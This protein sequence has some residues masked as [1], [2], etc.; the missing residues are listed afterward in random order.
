M[1]YPQSGAGHHL[2][3][4]SMARTRRNMKSSYFVMRSSSRRI[5]WMSF[6]WNFS[7]HSGH[8]ILI[9]LSEISICRY[10]FRQS[11]HDRWWQVMI[12][13]KLS[14]SWSTMQT[15]HS[16]QLSF[17]LDWATAVTLGGGH[18]T[19]GNGGG[20]GSLT[21][22]RLVSDRAE[23]ESRLACDLDRLRGLRT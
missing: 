3:S 19:I 4:G 5:I 7:A 6:G 20:G 23:S 12:S 8:A 15:G 2:A 11:R 1:T 21:T 9:R 10:C 17:L 18:G 22:F 14:R 16:L 13:G